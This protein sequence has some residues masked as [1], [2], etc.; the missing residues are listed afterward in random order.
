MVRQCVMRGSAE[1]EILL[2]STLIDEKGI[3]ESY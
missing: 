2:N 3:R 1:E